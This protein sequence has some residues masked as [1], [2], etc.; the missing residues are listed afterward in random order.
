MFL[1]LCS[2]RNFNTWKHRGG[3]DTTNL[4]YLGVRKWTRCLSNHVHCGRR[5]LK[6]TLSGSTFASDCTKTANSMTLHGAAGFEMQAGLNFQC[7]PKDSVSQQLSSKGHAHRNYGKLLHL[8]LLLH[9]DNIISEVDLLE[10]SLPV[11]EANMANISLA[12]C[13]LTGSCSSQKFPNHT[14]PALQT[15]TLMRP[16]W[17]VKCFPAFSTC[18][19]HNF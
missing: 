17:K 19:L 1:H 4:Y 15:E 5:R 7:F 3:G 2:K 8:S 12:Y 9:E 16:F 6:T 14:C 11:S 13:V 10:F 18:I